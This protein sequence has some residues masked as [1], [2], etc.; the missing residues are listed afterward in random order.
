MMGNEADEMLVKLQKTVLEM[1]REIENF[2]DYVRRGDIS[3]TAQWGHSAGLT[4]CASDL[5]RALAAFVESAPRA[6][7]KKG[8]EISDFVPD[9]P[10]P[11]PPVLIKV[12]G[13]CGRAQGTWRGLRWRIYAEMDGHGGVRGQVR[14]SPR[15]GMA[16][17]HVAD[18]RV[19][20]PRAHED[21]EEAQAVLAAI[22][23]SRLRAGE[24][25]VPYG[26]I[27]P[28]EATRPYG[29]DLPHPDETE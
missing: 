24:L 17:E 8:L 28:T 27:V 11:M 4:L 20:S 18:V 23:W 12:T 25:T 13:D 15:K 1:V 29:D 2:S 9:P 21:W 7:T 16:A 10:E 3:E 19:Y 22:L 6:Q 14:V 26:P 5:E